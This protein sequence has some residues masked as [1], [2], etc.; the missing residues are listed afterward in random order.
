MTDLAQGHPAEPTE[1][2]GRTDHEA[3]LLAMERMAQGDFSVRVPVPPTGQAAIFAEQFNQMAARLWEREA[4]HNMFGQYVTPSVTEAILRGDVKLGGER[5]EITVLI[6]DVRDFT[7]LTDNTEPER[8]VA[9]INR[10]FS[11]MIDAVVEFEG[12]LDKFLADALLVEYNAPLAQDHHALRAV[13]TALRMRERLVAFNENQEA[14]GE[15]AIRIGVGI[16]TGQ[17]IVGNMGSE[18]RRVE[19]TAMGETVNIAARLENRTKEAG[20]DIVIGANTYE[21]VREFIEVRAPIEVATRGRAK[22]PTGYPLIGLKPEYQLGTHLLDLASRSAAM[23]SARA[24][25]VASV[26][27][28]LT[29]SERA[30]RAADLEARLAAQRATLDAVMASMSDGLVVLDA[31]RQVRFCNAQAGAVLGVAPR[32]LIG[33]RAEVIFAAPRAT[34]AHPEGVQQAWERALTSVEAPP[35]FEVRLAGPSAGVFLAQVFPVTDAG[36]ARVGAGLVLRDVTAAEAAS[37]HKSQFLASMSH[38]LRTPLNA[39]LG[40][41]ELIVD[42]IYGEVP[43]KILEV[44]DRVRKSGHHLLGLI[45]AVLDLSKIEAGQLTLALNDYSLSDVIQTVVTAVE[46]LAVEQR[47]RLM[48]EVAPALPVGKGDERRLSQ[49]LLNL[50]GNAIKFTDAGEVRIKA[51]VADRNFVVSVADTGPGIA[52]AEQQKIFEEFHQ[53][54][55]PATRRKGGT[56]LGLSIAKRIVGLHGGRIWVESELG[57]GSTFTFTVPVRVEQQTEQVTAAERVETG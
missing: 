49:V 19:Y 27:S 55:G 7:A 48:A 32:D 18:G 57:R 51:V 35:A 43:E 42:G 29:P 11:A 53:V 45:N 24:A 1:P 56:G 25:P 38:E 22:S 26:P 31:A 15:P 40:Y 16:Y 14:R 46:P 33:Q 9:M 47:L 21:Y 44:M 52:E 3:L 13:L 10:Y 12:T 30:R 54:E 37:R 50:V 4:V 41:A 34:F 36:G 2:S 39:I 20:T 23:G 8:V 28:A 6:S 17:A 5:K